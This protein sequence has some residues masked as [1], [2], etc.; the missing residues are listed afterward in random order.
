MD[1]RL[2]ILG[3]GF[4]LNINY[5]TKYSD[6]AN[7]VKLNW[8]FDAA[9]EGLGGY[10]QHRAKTDNWLDLESA[11]LDYASSVGGAANPDATGVYPT[12]SDE[13]DYDRLVSALQVYIER[14]IDEDAVDSNS[15]AAK[16]L[17]TFLGRSGYSIY[18]FN[19]TNLQKVAYALYIKDSRY[20][21]KNYELDYTPVHGC[22]ETKDII[23]GVNGDAELIEGYEFLRK[24]ERPLYRK[25]NLLQD[26]F[27]SK[28]ITFFGL[29]MGKIDYPYFRDFWEVLCH[30]SVPKEEKRHITIFTY[31][32]LSMRQILNQLRSL[33]RTDL[34]TLQSNSYFEVIRTEECKWE[35]K[36]KFE[37]WIKRNA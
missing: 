4:D 13:F 30:G 34:L 20:E 29:S 22:I 14:V 32:T 18:S 15:I 26:L 7:K 11:L 35:D 16:V 24:N 9:K 5:R 12:E 19:Y 27:F 37:N 10:L 1:G 33:T 28:E 3:N 36:E 6:F 21:R 31:D 2:L 8:P 23:L 25:T 17:Q